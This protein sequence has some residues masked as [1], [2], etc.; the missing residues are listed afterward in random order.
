MCESTRCPDMV[1]A[2]P[3]KLAELSAKLSFAL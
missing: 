3:D 1:T 2:N